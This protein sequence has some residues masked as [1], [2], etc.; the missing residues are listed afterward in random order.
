MMKKSREK[1]DKIQASETY[2][3]FVK[4]QRNENKCGDENEKNYTRSKT[5]LKGRNK[6]K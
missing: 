6:K 3:I 2:P 4:A 1:N 5:M